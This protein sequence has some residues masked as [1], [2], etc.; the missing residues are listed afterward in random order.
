MQKDKIIFGVLS[1]IVLL[2]L[3]TA[4]V[5]FKDIPPPVN[6]FLGESNIVFFNETSIK[7]EVAD[8]NTKRQQGLSGRASLGDNEGMFFVFGK[9]QRGGIWMKDMHF[10]IDIIWLDKD[11]FVVYIK[12]NAQPESY[13]EIFYPQKDAQ[14][15]LEVNAN[16]TKQHDILIGD[17]AH[18]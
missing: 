14:Y 1:I 18:F 16:F 17:Q 8:T 3:F 10:P 15:V 4:G 5:F 6:S 9:P 11:L 2:F 13:P 12:Q 7:I